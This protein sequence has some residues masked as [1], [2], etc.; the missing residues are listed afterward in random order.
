VNCVAV[1][2]LEGQEESLLFQAQLESND[3]SAVQVRDLNVFHSYA[4]GFHSLTGV[5]FLIES[6]LRLAGGQECVGHF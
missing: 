3:D 6:S 5:V 1:P 2:S 4:C